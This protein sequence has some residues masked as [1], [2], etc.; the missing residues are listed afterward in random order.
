MF[1]K[2]IKAIHKIEKMFVLDKP[3]YDKITKTIRDKKVEQKFAIR[4]LFETVRFLGKMK[5]QL[6]L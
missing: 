4:K 2:P 3:H 1:E 5:Q 6:F